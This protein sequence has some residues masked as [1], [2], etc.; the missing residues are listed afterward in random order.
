MLNRGRLITA[1]PLRAARALLGIGQRTLAETA[2][3]SLPAMQHMETSR[4]NV[5][6]MVE[7][8]T[9]IVEALDAA[10][11]AELIGNEQARQS[12]GRGARL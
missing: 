5:R 4:G 2:D 11:G 10:A 6:G 3:V 12:R 7:T 9:R 1:V 8:P